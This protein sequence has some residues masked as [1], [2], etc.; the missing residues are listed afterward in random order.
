MCGISRG[1]GGII[2]ILNSGFP[3]DPFPW[4]VNSDLSTVPQ[5]IL[6][7]FYLLSLEAILL[8]NQSL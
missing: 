5:S 4:N 8:S 1:C 7:I 2:G 3:L 6:V